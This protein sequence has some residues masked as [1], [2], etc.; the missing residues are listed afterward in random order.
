M[1]YDRTCTGK[2]F[3]PGLSHA[4][5]T[6]QH[7]YRLLGRFDR[8]LGVE[9]WDEALSWLGHVGR[10]QP[11]A[12]IQYWG[13][14]KWGLARVDSQ[15]FDAAALAPSHRWAAD[16]DRIADRLLPDGRSL[17]W[18]RTCE[19]LGCAPGQ[20]FAQRL[21]ERLACRVAG[22]TYIIGHWQSG[23][24]SLAPGQTPGWSQDEGLREGTP[25]SPRE[26]YW[27][28]AWHPNTVSFLHGQIPAGY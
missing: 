24:H 20:D 6:G 23:L 10:G 5:A 7:L 13:H 26:A 18:F 14:G 3:R 12:E 28:R 8:T 1:V 2:P 15:A 11:I 9:S 16:L 4:W 27:S 19:T 17:L 21:T 25:E 22:H